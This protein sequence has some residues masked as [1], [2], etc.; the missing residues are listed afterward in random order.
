MNSNSRVVIK[1]WLRAMFVALL[2]ASFATSA[3][4]AKSND[5][6]NGWGVGN[7]GPSSGGGK[8][9][10]KPV[11]P[12]IDG[13]PTFSLMEGES[14]SFTPTASDRNCDTLTFSISGQPS[15]ATFNAADGTLSGKPPVGS[16]GSFPGISISVS[17]GT[18]T[19]SLPAFTITV[20]GNAAPVL[21]GTPPGRTATGQR[22]DFVPIAFDPD[23]QTLTFSISKRPSWASFDTKTGELSGT[24]S[25]SQV[26]TYNDI[27]VSAS[28]GLASSSIGPFTV[29]V[30]MGNR[31][32]V[33]SGSPATS[34]V[35]GQ[36]Y[37]F[38]PT[39]SDA[40]NDTLTFSIANQ[41]AWATFDAS[42]GRL[43]GTP[44]ESQ[45]GT[46]SG[47]AIS[48][49]DGK[50]STSLPAFNLAVSSS[51]HAPTISGSP[52]TS[53]VAGQTYAFAPTA[54][55]PDNDKLTF[56]IGNQPTWAT[57]DAATGRLSGTPG[58]AVAGEYI[59][60][61]ITV[62]DGELSASLPAFSIVVSVANRAPTI[63]GTPATTVTAGQPYR[64]VPNASDADGDPLTF[65]IV[66]QPSWAT[67]NTKTG[68]LAGTP[69]SDKA[70][71][72]SNIKI[73]VSDGK[74]TASL[75][76]FSIT[77]EQASMGSATLSWQPPTQR[78]DGT[79]LSDLKGYHILYG[80]APGSYP[81]RITLDNPGLTSYVVSNLSQGTWY[82]VMTAFD[83][84]GA[85]SSQTGA[86]SKT[87]Q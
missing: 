65:S 83:A 78:T 77:V 4:A 41:P 54:S 9:Q 53:V 37:A 30:E 7:G 14:Y 76:V 72:Y 45:A 66:N 74:L 48:V 63:S 58:T 21:S 19:A 29:V 50:T 62:S 38:T 60:I 73:S 80:S 52:S 70:A 61:V 1:Q 69:G 25:E 26:G 49:S 55:D 10:P 82:F 47:I 46:Y 35:A 79:Q 86:V 87:I 28:D 13:L 27:T 8:C 22:Y 24:P 59:G 11:A 34:V 31:A 15:W 39:A 51:N 33:I 42:T 68:E 43:S 18:S 84:N 6:G 3:I 71:I 67:F 85:E 17:D 75:P 64:F 32:P 40:D 12:T 2:A 57:F 20:Y 5:K 16:A 23:G 56:S 81:N 44:A 36:A